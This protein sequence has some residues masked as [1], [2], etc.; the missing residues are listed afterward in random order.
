MTHDNDIHDDE[1]APASVS[2]A[3][4]IFWLTVVLLLLSVAAG[5]VLV[6]RKFGPGAERRAVEEASEA[7]RNDVLDTLPWDRDLNAPKE[8]LRRIGGD[9]PTGWRAASGGWWK[10]AREKFGEIG[11]EGWE[12]IKRDWDAAAKAGGWSADMDAEAPPQSQSRLNGIEYLSRG[13]ASTPEIA[14]KLIATVPS[15]ALRT[16]VGP[17]L[18]VPQSGALSM[19]EGIPDTGCDTRDF[20]L[21]PSLVLRIA[22]L[23]SLKRTAEAESEL[24]ALGSFILQLTPVA[25]FDLFVITSLR[26]R[27]L[28]SV[29]TFAETGHLSSIAAASLVASWKQ[30]PPDTRLI[31]W[32]EG[33]LA[34]ANRD[35]LEAMNDPTWGGDVVDGMETQLAHVRRLF[36]FG[37]RTPLLTAIAETGRIAVSDRP[38]AYAAWL[39]IQRVN[40]RD[41]ESV[42]TLPPDAA[43]EYAGWTALSLAAERARTVGN[44]SNT[45][46]PSAESTEPF[47]VKVV[48]STARPVGAAPDEPAVP[49]V[50][51]TVTESPNYTHSG[52]AFAPAVVT[53]AARF[54]ASVPPNPAPPGR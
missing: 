45:P 7:L 26:E 22:A 29:L 10:A 1:P 20:G 39:D 44:A 53:L 42:A 16:Q 8:L 49:A 2:R 34:T 23:H 54:P 43:L 41:A 46:T 12:E 33:M 4:T 48:W 19:H 3:R 47:V 28:D 35:S 40:R 37:Q 38:A 31:P 51:V 24:V 32:F 50:T 11:G 25:G 15:P 18:C 36:E 52:P 14:N 5:G 27:V 17:L 13:L 21:W 30:H 9:H 6:Y